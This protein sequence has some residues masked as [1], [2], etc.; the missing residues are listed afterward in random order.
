MTDVPLGDEKASLE[1]WIAVFGGAIGA[2]IATLDISIV[3]SALP[4]IQGEVGASGTEGT[5]IATGYLVSEVVMIPLAAWLTRVLGLRTLLLT[6]TIFFMSFSMVCGVS[7]TLPMLVIGRVGQGFFGGALIPTAQTI[8]RTRLPVSQMPIGMSIFGMIVLLG[9]LAGPIVGGWLTEH[10]SWQWCFFLNIPIAAGLIALL[11]LGLPHEKPNVDELRQAD[12]LG[13]V[14][15][16]VGLS[17]LMVVLEEGQREHWFES[18]MIVWLTVATVAGFAVLV[19]AQFVS[20]RP[21]IKLRLFMNGSYASVILISVAV[22]MVLYGI[23]YILPQFLSGIDNYN[24]EQSGRILFIS[25]VPAI[26]MMPVLPMILRKAN[27]RLI[28]ILGM[29]CFSGSCLLDI[30]LTAD[31]SGVDFIPSQLLRGFGQMLAMIPLNQ[32][33]V[34][35]VSIEDAPDAAGIF[36]MSRNLGGSLGLALLGLF[37]DRRSAAH[38]ANIS[39]SVTANSPLA[40]SRIAGEAY[41]LGGDP[42]AG[43]VTAMAHLAGVAQQQAMVMTFSDALLLLGILL[44][45]M[46]PLVWL[47]KMPTGIVSLAQESH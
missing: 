4:Q 14:G 13:M 41:A 30:H 37:I 36:N 21:V 15:M 43:H 42:A 2:L 22:G 20:R 10:A 35:A 27:M 18:A 25:G 38:Y 12:W 8:T 31:S 1:D 28:V 29:L 40:Q 24:A 19:L 3:N 16:A 33:S 11:L 39:A 26:L 32:A 6:C 23:L 44:F 9:P 34:A 5:W 47:L 17:S 7:H 46:L 45:F